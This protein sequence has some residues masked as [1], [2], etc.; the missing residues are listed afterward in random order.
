M[1]IL[2]VILYEAVHSSRHV[3]GFVCGL[4]LI[5][6]SDWS[7]YLSQA[8]APVMEPMTAVEMCPYQW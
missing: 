1:Y 7:V 6:H 3:H 2:W 8:Q 5:P 4:L